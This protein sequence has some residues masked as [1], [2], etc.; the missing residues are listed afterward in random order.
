MNQFYILLIRAILS[1]AFAVVLGRVFF[2]DA[3]PV[4]FAGLGIFLLGA[5]YLA[6]YLRN[7]KGPEDRG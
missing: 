6:E 7:R 2:P 3:N 1:A 5:A 4:A